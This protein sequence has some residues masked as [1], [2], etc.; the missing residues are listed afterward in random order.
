V[1]GFFEAA[2]N[3]KPVETKKPTV[4]I[5]GKKLDVDLA[6]FKEVMKHGENAFKISN[7]KITRR[8][9]DG[10]KKEYLS[11]VKADKGVSLMDSH[12]YWPDQVV[13]GGF[14]WQIL[15]E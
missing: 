1:P 10:I 13:E 6:V 9:V 4:I 7:G 3:W 5:D 11:L 8:R 2:K 15:S 14:E 12:P